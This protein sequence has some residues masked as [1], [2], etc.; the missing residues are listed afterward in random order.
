MLSA[1][2]FTVARYIAIHLPSIELF[3][4]EILHPQTNAVSPFRESQY[5]YASYQLLSLLFPY[6]FSFAPLTHIN[7]PLF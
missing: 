7:P 5:C 6:S 1:M 2:A 4:A 3:V